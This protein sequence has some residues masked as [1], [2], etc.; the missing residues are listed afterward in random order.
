VAPS[1]G[2][3]HGSRLNYSAAGASA[4][5]RDPPKN[6]LIAANQMAADMMQPWRL[7]AYYVHAAGLSE[8]KAIK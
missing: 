3:A 7:A 2:Q 1:K 4:Q 5:V 6:P 8:I